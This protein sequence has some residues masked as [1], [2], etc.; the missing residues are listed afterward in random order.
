MIR[1]WTIYP[2][3]QFSTEFRAQ[4][5]KIFQTSGVS[6]CGPAGVGKPRMTG[7]VI[8][9]NGDAALSESGETFVLLTA[10]DYPGRG[11]YARC[12]T[13]DQPYDAVIS[14]VLLLAMRQGYVDSFIHED[15]ED[16]HAAQ[17]L[18]RTAALS[19]Q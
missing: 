14:A 13:R 12:D 2:G 7:S 10:A 4:V 1:R 11:V 6:I 16:L 3:T 18:I 15:A 9:F 5:R 8:Q 19:G 17:E